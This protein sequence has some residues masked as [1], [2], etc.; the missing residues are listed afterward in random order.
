MDTTPFIIPLLLLCP[1][2][3]LT[4]LVLLGDRR[5][6]AALL[7]QKQRELHHMEQQFA[8]LL[9]RHKELQQFRNSMSEAEIT[10]RLQSPRLTANPTAA[11]PRLNEKYRLILTLAEKKMD[12]AEIA[13]TLSLS[14]EEVAQVLAL[15]ALNKS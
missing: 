2:F 14:T 7:K 8:I 5:K 1:V 11:N 12:C 15:S 10:T 9:E 13:A 3:L 6:K 4:I